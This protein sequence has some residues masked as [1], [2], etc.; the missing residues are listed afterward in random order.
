M[1]EKF[2]YWLLYI[3]ILLVLGTVIRFLWWLLTS[4]ISALV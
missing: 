1:K 4:I 3:A 2:K